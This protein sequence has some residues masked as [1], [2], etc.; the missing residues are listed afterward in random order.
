MTIDTISLSDVR[1]FILSNPE[2]KTE[3]DAV[4]AEFESSNRHLLLTISPQSGSF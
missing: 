3:Y 2:V 1:D 4:K